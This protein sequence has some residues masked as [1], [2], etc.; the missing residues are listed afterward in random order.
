[1]SALRC[2]HR[3]YRA[4]KS[5]S[6][7]REVRPLLVVNLVANKFSDGHVFFKECFSAKYADDR[8]PGIIRYHVEH[9]WHVGVGVSKNGEGRVAGGVRAFVEPLSDKGL[10]NCVSVRGAHRGCGHNGVDLNLVRVVVV[11]AEIAGNSTLEHFW[12]GVRNK[13]AAIDSA[14]TGEKNDVLVGIR[15]NL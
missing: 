3:R 13:F 9:G 4:R 6:D 12:R 15:V 1:M 11:V 10:R 7:R 5:E 8:N 2:A 14:R